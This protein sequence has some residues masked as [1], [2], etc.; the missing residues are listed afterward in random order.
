MV[1]SIGILSKNK[2]TSASRPFIAAGTCKRE[3]GNEHARLI[4][5]VID[6]CNMEVAIIGWPLF[7]VASDGES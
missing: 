4:S 5:S 6:T 1:F 2:H 3:N 7:C